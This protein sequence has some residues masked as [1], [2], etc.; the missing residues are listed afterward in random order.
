MA[1][2][3]QLVE[4]QQAAESAAAAQTPSA[5]PNRDKWLANLKAKYGEDKTDEELYD[6]SMS[7]YDADH[8]AVKR[9]NEEATELQDILNENPDLAGVFSEI[10]E[11]GKDGNPAGA[12]RNLP[13]E[14]KRLI[15]D[16]E[17]G[18]EAYLADKKARE[19]A[20]FEEKTKADHIEEMR[21]QAFS[22]VLQENGITGEDEVK[23][24]L[25][26][27]QSVLMNPCEDLEQCKEQARAFLKMVGYDSAVKAAEIRGRNANIAEQRRSVPKTTPQGSGAGVSTKAS[28][29][30]DLFGQ[31]AEA[32]KKQRDKYA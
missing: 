15:T 9:Y 21:E 7:G 14:L 19:D 13:P 22:E 29:S 2:K 27:I 30:N 5:T 1:K 17:Y 10:F 23:A 8:D 24:T 28:G 31:I 3:E 26:A 32:T 12:L 4:T 6:L 11:R 25:E 18:D 20:E 16:E